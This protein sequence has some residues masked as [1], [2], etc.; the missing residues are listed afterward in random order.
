MISKAVARYQPIAPRKARLVA[1]LV[2]N[3]TVRDALDILSFTRKRASGMIHKVISSAL[4][5]AQNIDP[6][7]DEED[8]YIERIFV[9]DGGIRYWIKPR[10]RGMAYRIRRRRCHITVMLDVKEGE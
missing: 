8:L 6:G 3:Q 2:R 1:D 5:N 7:Y 10:A 9:D 4:A